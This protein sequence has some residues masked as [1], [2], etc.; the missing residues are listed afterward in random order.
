MVRK[1]YVNAVDLQETSLA[2]EQFLIAEYPTTWTP[3]RIDLFPGQLP[4]GFKSLGAVVEDSPSFKV[5]KNKYTL[6]TGIPAVRQYERTIGLEGTLEFALHSTSWRKLQVALGNL[7]AVSSATI[8]SSVG[9]I[10]S[11]SIIHLSSAP[12]TPITVG[13][14][15]VFSAAGQQ[16]GIDTQET[17]LRSVVSVL[18]SFTSWYVVPPLAGSPAG[19]ENVYKYAEVRQYYGTAT[20]REFTLLGVADF[21]D[22][23]QIVH[24]FPRVQV[25]ADVTREIRP[26]ENLRLPLTFNL[27]A[28]TRTIR[29]N[30]ELILAQES[31]FP[32]R[33][34]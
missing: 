12:T 28:V 3:G 22:G 10:Q 2:I 16:D 8:V 30:D 25:A 14:Q 5:T 4:S 15:V 1:S 13:D 26:G 29:G 17:V 11:A 21:V 33:G 20:E 23:Y 9:S 6:Q 19:T 7:T 27:F 34:V 18:A 32:K 31:Y 24:E